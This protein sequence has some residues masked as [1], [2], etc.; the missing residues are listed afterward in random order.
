MNTF[1]LLIAAAIAVILYFR[2]NREKYQLPDFTAVGTE[3]DICPEGYVLACVSADLPGIVNNIPFPENLPKPCKEVDTPLC[4]PHPDN[5]KP[6][7]PE[8]LLRVI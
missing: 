3:S 2:A 6:P 5:I 7:S 1:T 4:L 8:Y